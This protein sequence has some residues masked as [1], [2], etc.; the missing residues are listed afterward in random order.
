MSM[1]FYC[2]PNDNFGDCVRFGLTLENQ[3]GKHLM[4]FF[5]FGGEVGEDNSSFSGVN[6]GDLDGL[7]SLCWFDLNFRVLTLLRLGR[8][9]TLFSLVGISILRGL[10]VL[11]SMIR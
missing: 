9:N 10:K 1:F 11:M 5:F 3:M 7:S 2:Y 8:A 4:F 6:F